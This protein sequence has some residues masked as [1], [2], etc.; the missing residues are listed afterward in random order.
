M[1]I[2]TQVHRQTLIVRM[3]G[4]L[5]HHNSVRLRRAVDG[6]LGRGVARN[7]V[8]NLHGL[9]FMDSSGVGVILG[10]YRL[11]REKGGGMVLCR[12]PETVRRVLFISGVPRVIPFEKN[13]KM[14]LARCR[15]CEEVD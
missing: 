2:Q 12:V 13:E 15:S 6:L 3:Q 4:E 9:S 1:E 10:R 8:L 7:L 5:D 14:A 11:V